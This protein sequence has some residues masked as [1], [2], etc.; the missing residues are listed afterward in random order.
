M[1]EENITR[2]YSPLDLNTPVGTNVRPWFCIM[3]IAYIQQEAIK[4]LNKILFKITT[5][6]AEQVLYTYMT[7]KLKPSTSNNSVAY[8][9]NRLFNALLLHIDVSHIPIKH[10]GFLYCNILSTVFKWKNDD[11]IGQ[12]KQHSKWKELNHEQMPTPK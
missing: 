1:F 11:F 9:Q 12:R 4:K 3:R 6:K 8:F 2:E 5:S 10:F 7:R